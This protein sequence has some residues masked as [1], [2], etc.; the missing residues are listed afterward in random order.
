M[1]DCVGE[2]QQCELSCDGTCLIGV[3]YSFCKVQVG[4]QFL[5]E[6]VKKEGNTGVTTVLCSDAMMLLSIKKK[7]TP[8]GGVS[9]SV[10]FKK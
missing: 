9:Y 10:T 2:I 3:R 4:K 7:T 8:C 1:A 6:W 5:E